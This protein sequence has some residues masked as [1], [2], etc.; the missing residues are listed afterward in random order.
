MTKMTQMER[1]DFD[2]GFNK[3]LHKKALDF[4]PNTLFRKAERVEFY[5]K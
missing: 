1:Q 2:F 3:I 4:Y 5:Q